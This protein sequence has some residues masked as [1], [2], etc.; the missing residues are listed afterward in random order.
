MVATSVSLDASMHNS[1]HEVLVPMWLDLLRSALPHREL[2]SS[3]AALEHALLLLPSED[4][5]FLTTHTLPWMVGLMVRAEGAIFAGDTD[6]VP[7]LASGSKGALTFTQ[8]QCAL[9]VVCAFF[10]LYPYRSYK[11]GSSGRC[12]GGSRKEL[13]PFTGPR[14]RDGYGRSLGSMNMAS[15][16]AARAHGGGGGGNYTAPN[17]L[18]AEHRF[19]HPDSSVHNKVRCILHYFMSLCRGWSDASL[20][21]RRIEFARWLLS[22]NTTGITMPP[23]SGAGVAPASPFNVSSTL[24]VV[25]FDS[26]LLIEKADGLLQVDFANSCLGGGV[27]GRGCVQEEIRFVVCPDMF[28]ARLVCE[29]L[30][31]LEAVLMNGCEQYCDYSGYG[32]SFSFKC[33]LPKAT[34]APAPP[35]QSPI[36]NVCVVAID[37]TNFNAT[38]LR[39]EFQY[40]DSWI[41][42]DFHKALVGF[43]GSNH[44]SLEAGRPVANASTAAAIATG[45]WGCGAFGGDRELKFLLQWVAASLVRR[46]LLYCSFGDT[47]FNHR[48]QA[49]CA[50][51]ASTSPGQLLSAVLRAGSAVT[52]LFEDGLASFPLGHGLK[53]EW[54]AS[55]PMQQNASAEEHLSAPAQSDFPLSQAEG[56]EMV[57][58]VEESVTIT[59]EVTE[60]YGLQGAGAVEPPSEVCAEEVQLVP[61]TH[62]FLERVLLQLGLECAL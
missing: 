3:F 1:A 13:V 61:D 34:I 35:H 52:E 51:V 48:C 54:K 7:I 36:A 50:A 55:Q 18:L 30:G 28:V 6:V 56:N 10:S 5:V 47:E 58:V 60:E 2:C 25:Q 17:S 23:S 26:E 16:F 38:G 9:L 37:A 40:R 46:N 41:R 11:V 22:E 29:N 8:E 57:L 49:F 62:R 59:S 15:L 45:H 20:R 33:T 24:S 43:L 32:K 39:P 12:P 19:A 21:T 44:S 42:K 4:I 31:P 27:L 53:R 14:G